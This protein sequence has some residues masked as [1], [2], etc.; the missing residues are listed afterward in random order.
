MN[1]DVQPEPDYLERLVNAAAEQD[2]WFATGKLLKAGS[3]GIIDGTF[4]LI[5]RSGCAWRAGEGRPDGAIWS[6]PRRIALTSFTASVFRTDLFA[7]L[8]GLDEEFGSYLEDVDF[9]IRCAM[10]SRD[11]VYVPDAKAWHESSATLGVWAPEMV[12]LIARNQLLL[13]AKH[14]PRDWRKR[15]GRE[16]IAGQLLWGLMALVR[17]RGMAFVQGKREAWRELDR[18]QALEKPDEQL[19]ASLLQSSEEQIRQ[20]QVS[21]GFDRYWKW[22]FA[23][24]GKRR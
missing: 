9:G 10:A 17:G 22:Y 11:G 19:L 7:E 4:D 23:A 21:A 20:L 15:Y 3:N 5:A 8:G 1:N 18:L 2:A 13:V 14:Y 16:V 6:Q 24:A 12:R